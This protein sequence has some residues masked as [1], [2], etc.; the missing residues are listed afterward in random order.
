MARSTTLLRRAGTLLGLLA[1]AVSTSAQGSAIQPGFSGGG[2]APS[3]PGGVVAGRSGATTQV[4]DAAGYAGPGD[5]TNAPPKPSPTAP[6]APQPSPT[7]AQAAPPAPGLVQLPTGDAAGG[8]AVS[9]PATTAGFV[10]EPDW[11]EWTLWW[12]LNRHAYLDLR[13]HVHAGGS[14]TGS[15][16]FFLGFG[17][18]RQT[19]DV[20]RPSERQIRERVLPALLEALDREENPIVVRSLLIALAKI[21]DEPGPTG[22]SYLAQV[23]RGYLKE[24]NQGVEETAAIALGILG[25]DAALEDLVALVTDSYEGRR[26]LVEDAEVTYRTRAFAAYGLGLLGSDTRSEAVRRRIVEVL[27]RTLTS[28]DS[29]SDDLGV[30]CVLALGL[31]PLGSIEPDEPGAVVP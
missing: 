12:E 24:G 21:G 8:L 6:Q 9:Q 29:P 22:G 14:G 27:A 23:L 17:E 25:A 13:R 11:T 5:G 30:A 15:D 19:R 2:V 31:V 4:H 1:L 7:G 16:E 26:R 28:D 10:V 20:L 3:K 18:R